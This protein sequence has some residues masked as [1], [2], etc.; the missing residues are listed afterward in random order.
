MPD[1]GKLPWELKNGVKEFHLTAEH[2]RR[3]VLPGMHFD[4]WGYNGS[5]P[6]PMIEANQGDRVRI[7]VHNNLPEATTVHWHGL[8]LP[9]AMDG[10]PGL[11]QEPIPPGGKFVYE[12]DLHQHGTFFYHSHGAMQEI[13]GM[14]GLFVI[15]PRDAFEPT[16]DHDFGLIMQQFAILPQSTIPN[17]VSEEFNFFTLNGRSGPYVTPLVVR[18]G[19]RVRIRF[20]NLSAMDHHPMHLHG[21]TFWVTGTEGGRIPESAWI[22]TNN[23]LVSV[24]QSR[25]VEFIANNPGDWMLHCHILHHMMNHMVSMVGPMP[26]MASMGDRHESHGAMPEMQGGEFASG[27]LGAGLERS[28]GPSVGADRQVMTGMRPSEMKAKFEV[29]GYPQDMMEMHGM[30]TPDQMKKVNTAL[31]R[32]MR[33][34]WPMGTQAMMTVLRVLPDDLYEKVIS[35]Q[36]EIEPGASVPGAGP[37]NAN[38]SGHRMNGGSSEEPSGS[39]RHHHH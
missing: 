24:G 39:A 31:T 2:V 27:E 20:M 8:E 1:L 10:V 7:I 15:H 32:G 29:P 13:M 19:S 22:P 5:M 6:G 3:E 16:V 28:L 18:L 4:F 26:S 25:D 11:T 14:M 30:L 23:V 37:G 36:G 38:H 21:H 9:V 34:N 33:R 12:F 35:G 17:S